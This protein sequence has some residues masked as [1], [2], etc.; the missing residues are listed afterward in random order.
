MRSNHIILAAAALLLT[1]AAWAELPIKVLTR[2]KGNTTRET[3][4]VVCQTTP[5]AT[6]TINGEEAHVYKTGAFGLP[7]K[8]EPGTNKV[9]V[10]VTMGDESAEKTLTFNYAPEEKKASTQ[11]EEPAVKITPASFNIRTKEGAYLTYSN[12]GDRLGGSK[13]E[14]VDEGIVAKVL[15]T[16]GDLYKIRL[17]DNRF[18]FIGKEYA[19]KTDE[20]VPGAMNSLNL[21]VTNIGKYDQVSLPLPARTMYN[22]WMD[23]DPTILY[24]DVYG[25]MNNSNWLTHPRNLE[26]IDYVEV[27]QV[28]SDILRL[29]IKLQKSHAWGYKIGFE[30]N[31]LR[32]KVKHA[33]EAV[34]S[35]LHIGLDAGHGGS[36]LGAVSVTGAYEKNINLSIVYK[37]KSILE[38]KGAKVTLTRETDRDVSMAERR[39]TMLDA[40]VDL[41]VSIH[42]NA[43]GNSLKPMGTSTYYKY[44]QNR[45]LAACVID[46]LLELEGVRSMGLVGNFNFALGTPIEYPTFLVE[47]LF[48][49][50][51]PDEEMLLDEEFQTRMAEKIVLGLEDYLQEA[52][53]R[54]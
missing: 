27:R 16:C 13:M 18:A 15:G 54:P 41:L 6:A 28:D 50:S 14:F 35:K 31:S 34:L 9:I 4:N 5:G 24:V 32:I 11:K 49:D 2:T 45:Q 53:L 38:K 36:S 12:G 7:V 1:S 21:S 25:V 52:R 40:D 37:V 17:S 23:L 51:L 19:E 26:M 22:S 44:V 20:A 29:V 42:N 39:Q 47:G 33:P 8:M 3:V 43:S 46:R 10:K 30:G 48:V